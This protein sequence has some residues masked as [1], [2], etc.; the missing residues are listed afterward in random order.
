[1]SN[2]LK[3]KCLLPFPEHHLFI[4]DL[5]LLPPTPFFKHPLHY[6]LKINA[7]KVQTLSPKLLPFRSFIILSGI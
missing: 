6:T 2:K 5:G 7:F 1:M 3:Q 4:P